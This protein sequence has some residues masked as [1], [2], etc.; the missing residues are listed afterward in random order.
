MAGWCRALYSLRMRPS[1]PHHPQ[2]AAAGFSKK[3]SDRQ[4]YGNPS[5]M[6][7]NWRMDWVA[8]VEARE[9]AEDAVMAARAQ[10]LALAELQI[11]S[12]APTFFQDLYDQISLAASALNPYQRVGEATKW[13]SPDNEQGMRISIRRV[14]IVANLTYTDLFCKKGQN[15][16]LCKTVEG[17]SFL[18]SFCI[19]Q[20][21]DL[22]V[23]A[24]GNQLIMD[25]RQSARFIVE[26]MMKATRF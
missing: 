13:G 17:K 21:G 2:D 8:Q 24:N 15:F 16:I 3:L 22:G 26:P 5:P 14:G 19:D 7:E 20:S 1:L 10:R 4:A 23:T 9:T 18:L 12:G 25:H 11:K 6:V